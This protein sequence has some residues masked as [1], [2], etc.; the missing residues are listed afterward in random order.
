M[1]IIWN[2]DCVLFFWPHCM[3]FRMLVPGL[4][5][6]PA[7]WAVKAQSPNSWIAREFLE[8]RF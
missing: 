3:A 6:E 2:S 8:F 7:L 4:Q 1:T 5:I